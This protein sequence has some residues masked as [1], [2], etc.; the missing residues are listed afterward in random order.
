MKPIVFLGD[1]ASAAGFRLAGIATCI[2]VAGREEEAFQ[3]ARGDAAVLLVDA[4]CAARLPP[5]VLSAAQAAVQP[6]LLVLPASPEDVP[7]GDPAAH[8]RRL[9][10][11]AP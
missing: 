8:V 11:L 1:E 4:R 7:P 5:A 3:R 10:G 9:L 2:V 6:L